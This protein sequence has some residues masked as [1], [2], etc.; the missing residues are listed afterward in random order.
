[1]RRYLSASFVFAAFFLCVS[2]NANAQDSTRSDVVKDQVTQRGLFER[3]KIIGNLAIQTGR[4]S[5]FEKSATGGLDY[6]KPSKKMRCALAFNI[7]YNLI[8]K[9]Y[10]RGTFYYHLN[11]N[12]N[13]K[14]NLV[15]YSYVLERANWT[16][17]T[18]SYGYTNYE[19]NHYSANLNDFTNSLMRG[20]YY[21]RYYNKLPDRWIK[22]IS[23]DSTTSLS[24]SVQ[25]KYAVKYFDN[26]NGIHGGILHGKPVVVLTSR[27]AFFK[28]MYIEGAVNI[29][30][31]QETKRIYDPEYTYGFG[32][33]AYRNLSLAFSYENYSANR[34]PWH[35]QSV[36]G[37][38][39]VDGIFSFILNY[40]L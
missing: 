34:F 21:V 12:I 36:K 22:K 18:F 33:N 23:I 24:Y 26:D 11:Q 29:Y 10:V 13:A 27:Y 4:V 5:D 31:S 38:S 35:K 2:L 6:S 30:L 39:F 40:S 17:N 16:P 20:S 25:I 14:W 7:G 32:Y 15:D 9:V 3:G 37:Y 19:T 28:N 1:M 8:E